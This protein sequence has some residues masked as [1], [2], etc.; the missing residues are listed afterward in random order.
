MNI[1]EYQAK[2]LLGDFGINVAKGKIAFNPNEALN[3]AK[4]IGGNVWAI[5]AQIHAGGRG[6]G[7]G[8]KIAK[9]LDEVEKYANDIIGMNLVTAQTGK[10]GKLVKKVYVEQGTDIAKEF[11]LSFTFDRKSEKIGLI[12]SAEG[13]MS[14]EEVSHKNPELIKSILID[15][16]IGLCDFHSMEVASF[17]KFDKDLSIKFSNLLTKLYKLYIDTDANLVEIN[18]LVLTAQNEFIPLDAKMGFDD[19]AMYRQEKIAKMR[20]LDEEEP[21]EV[22]AKNYGL[23]YVKL[24]G[25]IGCMVNGAGLAMGTMDT[26]NSVGGKPANFLDVGGG[27]S[28]ETVAKAFEIIL[29]DKNVKAIFVN[30][31]GGIV[32]CDRIA[33]GILEATK[34]T[35]VNVPVVVR[36]DGTNAKEAMEILKSANI[37]NIISVDGLEDGAKMAIKLA[38]EGE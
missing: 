25:N 3:A 23:S 6:L 21:S 36:L 16:Q 29:R 22:E 24:D 15:P 13:G 37:E 32:R 8:V 17:L 2:E 7:G 10:E 20:D 5:K 11:Y 33:N 34:L 27:A 31:F 14:I 30:I 18:P 26:I 38:K 12:A 28:P 35:K 9:N 19:S 1:H 4:E